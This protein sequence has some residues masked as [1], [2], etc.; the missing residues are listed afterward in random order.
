MRPPLDAKKKKRV[1]SISMTPLNWQI[2]TALALDQKI[3]RSKMVEILVS[4]AGL[5]LGIQGGVEPHIGS[6]EI[7]KR[8]GEHVDDWGITRVD[9]WYE[10][11][12]VACNP[13][14]L[15][16]RCQNPVCQAAYK[17]EGVV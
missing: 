16:G 9:G 14:T 3:S 17:K 11:A 7:L 15:K 13:Y 10:T 5:K 2:L 12:S 6:P 4:E 8:F 1:G